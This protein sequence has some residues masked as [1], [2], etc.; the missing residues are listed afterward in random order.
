MPETTDNVPL[1]RLAGIIAEWAR[2]FSVVKTVYIFGSRVR[3]DHNP[4]SDLDVAV[5][6]DPSQGKTITTPFDDEFKSGWTILKSMLPY[7]I[8]LE[9]HDLSNDYIAR[10]AIKAG[11]CVLQEGK[12]R[13][14]KTRTKQQ[15]N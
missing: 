2:P 12:V 11:K 15:S 8:K 4:D 3:E 10:R 6:F 7:G 13:C 5:K 14:I 1:E 9:M